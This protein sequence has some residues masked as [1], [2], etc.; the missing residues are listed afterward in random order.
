LAT[1][2]GVRISGVGHYVPEAVLS[3]A[4]LERTLDTSDAWITTRTGMKERRISA[5]G[6][7]T[8]DLATHAAR[9]ALE[10]ARLESAEIDCFVVATFTPDYLMPATACLVAA[11]LGAIGAAAFDVSIACS[12]FVYG[13]VVAAS[14]VRSGTFRRVMLVGAET[15]SAVTDPTDRGTAILFGDGAGAVVLEAAERDDLLASDLG[16]DGRTP[17]LLY[18]PARG[19]AGDLTERTLVER[20]HY[21]RMQGREVY[22]F[23]VGKMVESTRRVMERAGLLAADVAYVLPHQANLRIIDAAAKQLDIPMERV[24]I[25]IERYGNTSAASIPILL[26]EAVADGRLREGDPLIFVGFGGGLSWGAVA[27][28]WAV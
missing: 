4:D 13:L 1:G 20:R 21:M 17:E 19:T 6:E 11:R 5:P 15:C 12:G 25:N 26:S 9:R 23:A 2:V 7:R 10:A 8:S 16:A 18:I 28:R 3:N 22:R 27:W 24:L 14:L